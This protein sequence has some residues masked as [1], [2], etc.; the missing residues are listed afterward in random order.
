M[1]VVASRQDK[2]GSEETGNTGQITPLPTHGQSQPGPTLHATSASTDRS[3]SNERL[4]LANESREKPTT[5]KATNPRA[6]WEWPAARE[7]DIT[8]ER[9]VAAMAEYNKPIEA[10]RRPFDD[11]PPPH[12]RP[13][14]LL[15]GP[16]RQPEPPKPPGPSGSS[17]LSAASGQAPV[18]HALPRPQPD[19]RTSGEGSK[20]KIGSTVW[21]EHKKEALAAA[22]ANVLNAHYGK[23]GL[24]ISPVSVHYL[25]DQN[26]SYAQ[27]CELLE[28]RGFAIDRGFFARTLISAVP[29]LSSTSNAKTSR[30][31]DRPPPTAEAPSRL[32]SEDPR[33]S[34]GPSKSIQEPV[35]LSPKSVSKH[36][37]ARKRNFSEI[38][39]LS[40]DRSDDE[41]V[42]R[43]PGPH[44][45]SKSSSSPLPKAA[46]NG[47]AIRPSR[48]EYLR[49][50][51]IV[52]PLN[53][54]RDAFRRSS[55]DPRT[56]CE[57]FL[58]ACGKHPTEAPL[59]AHL[60]ILR[61][62]FDSVNDESDLSTLR[63]D[64]LD[65]EEDDLE[66]S[67]SDEAETSLHNMNDEDP[68]PELSFVKEEA[69]REDPVPKS[70]SSNRHPSITIQI[71]S[72]TTPARRSIPSRDPG[73]NSQDNASPLLKN[74][75]QQSK[76]LATSLDKAAFIRSYSFTP[77]ATSE[78]PNGTPNPPS[79][80]LPSPY[81]TA[82]SVRVP[83]RV[84]R[85]PGAKNRHPRS[86]KG[87]P[88]KRPMQFETTGMSS[89]S[90]PNTPASAAAK[91]TLALRRPNASNPSAG[92]SIVLPTRS[93]SV[94]Q[95]HSSFLH[96]QRMAVPNHHNSNSS[97]GRGGI[98]EAPFSALPP[99]TFEALK[100]RWEGCPAELHN[101][102]TLWKHIRKHRTRLEKPYT[103][104][105]AGCAIGG[106][107][108][109]GNGVLRFRTHDMEAW[110]RHM[111]TEHLRSFARA[112]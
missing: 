71:S 97:G 98:D 43:H 49:K 22:A 83:G 73:S 1:S 64:L 30:L 40:Q 104:K 53:K 46:G 77:A 100:C 18:P 34:N 60:N 55:Y 82:K 107:G 58:I 27:L 51:V 38:I 78:V 61:E 19:I 91:E 89:P 15:P 21:P 45:P 90:K 16:R 105:W 110:D 62:R 103:C 96:R 63:W 44:V 72:N 109:G 108:G 85:P 36:D 28:K 41:D 2:S 8:E 59:N 5:E 11:A 31:A 112:G 67:E 17:G 75:E 23:N 94:A 80:S 81:A 9:L 39:D 26:P 6:T 84:G 93:P 88:K 50:E 24:T 56:I 99:K 102:E 4:P 54:R 13:Q 12:P 111:E 3:T 66:D 69:V 47:V 33:S 48:R 101:L 87:V 65:P 52:Q 74:T 68:E 25:L 37:K 7:R 29:D 20:P 86:D 79:S 95:S 32:T 14:S 76:P 42:N 106:D 92:I 57:D 10:L 70:S 35:E